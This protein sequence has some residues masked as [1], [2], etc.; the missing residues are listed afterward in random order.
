MWWLMTHMRKCE[1][2]CVYVCVLMYRQDC[3]KAHARAR[4]LMICVPGT[5]EYVR[6][7]VNGPET[8]T[9]AQ[10][11]MCGGSRTSAFP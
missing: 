8:W 6:A 2:V 9:C 1:S 7:C 3:V 5:C 11:K 4:L 10:A